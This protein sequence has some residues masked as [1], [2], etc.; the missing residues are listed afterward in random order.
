MVRAKL[1]HKKGIS[2]NQTLASVNSLKHL[3]LNHDKRQSADLG[4]ELTLNESK[5]K[6]VLKS[7]DN[8]GFTI[9]IPQSQLQGA[10]SINYYA[11]TAKPKEKSRVTSGNILTDGPYLQT[12]GNN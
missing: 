1:D 11:T 7:N 12:Y 4:F 6:T 3:K 8:E 10:P 9:E 2:L 5:E